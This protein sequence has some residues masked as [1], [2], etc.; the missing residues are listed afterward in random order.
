[1]CT[2]FCCSGWGGGDVCLF[3]NESKLIGQKRRR[4]NWKEETRLD[5]DS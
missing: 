5:K 1:M 4:E 3:L 2:F